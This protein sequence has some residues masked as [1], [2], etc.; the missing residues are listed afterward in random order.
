MATS[1]Y[2]ATSIGLFI[3]SQ[4]NGQWGVDWRTLSDRPLTGVT[5]AEEVILA[6]SS[7]GLWRSADGGNT[8][9]KADTSLSIPYVRWLS[10]SSTPVSIVLVGTE[11]AAIFVSTDAGRSWAMDPGVL[12]LRDANGWFLPYSQRS[13]CVRGF[14][15][16]ES[17]PDAGRIY[18]AVEVGGVLVSDDHGRSWRLAA[19]SDGRPDMGRELGT[20]IHPDLHS[21][22]V[23][24]SS[25][26]I[27]TAATGAGLFRSTD[28]GRRWKNIL[29]AYIRAVWVDPF[30][31]RHLVAGPA[32]GVARNGRIEASRDGGRTW[33]PAVEGMRTP[34]AQHMV[35][36]FA[37]AH[38]ELVAVL[39]NG[40]LWSRRLNGS[41]WGRV[42]PEISR[43]TA[44]AAKE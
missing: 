14:A 26:D 37:P 1:L 36:R 23:H 34:W 5:V 2:I 17:G 29:P 9:E 35:E 30:D 25:S 13:G 28:G 27:V 8:W 22:S 24:P 11:P 32:D 6:G 20:R 41:R 18:A 44:V 10:A 31:P 15:V 7:E 39:S 43:A 4:T 40:E 16:A 21:I 33:H 19:G 42:L 3:A 38:G 12:A